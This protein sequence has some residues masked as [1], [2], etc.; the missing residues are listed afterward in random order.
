MN[1]ERRAFLKLATRG[2]VLLGVLLGATACPGEEARNAADE[3][4]EEL[5]DEAM[6]AKEEIEDEIDDHT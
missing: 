3:A 2:T 6:D 4:I 1:V 5:R